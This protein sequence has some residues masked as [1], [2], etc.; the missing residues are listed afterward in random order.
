MFY[1]LV[2]GEV[3][4]YSIEMEKTHIPNLAFTIF[5]LATLLLTIVML[6]LLIAII[7][8]TYNKVKM[9]QNLANNFER[10]LILVEIEKTMSKRTRTKLNRK[11]IILKYLFVGY[12][13]DDMLFDVYKDKNYED[14]M[15]KFEELDEKIKKIEE[16][17]VNNLVEIKEHFENQFL[18]FYDKLVQKNN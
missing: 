10:A 8:D 9:S 18:S 3:G 2:L 15:N 6:N 11:N 12:C 16:N 13:M 7:G 5:L 17:Q 1:S 4:D 14:F